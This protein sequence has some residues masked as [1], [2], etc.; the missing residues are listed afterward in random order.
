MPQAL[1]L[2]RE[3][4]R[5]PFDA[6]AGYFWLPRLIDKARAYFAGTLGEYAEYPC[7]SDKRFIAFYGLDADA[8]GAIIKSGA[9]DDEIAAWV[10]EHQIART[11][12]ETADFYRGLAKPPADPGLASYLADQAKAIAPGRTDIDSF[13]KLI[14]VEEKHPIPANLRR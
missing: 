6:L 10:M 7:G 2:S 11:V 1:D 5:S 3:V 4:P 9:S 12:E 13:A 14:C 8:L